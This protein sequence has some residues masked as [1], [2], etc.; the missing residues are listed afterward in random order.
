MN[1][2]QSVAARASCTGCSADRSFNA[3]TLHLYYYGFKTF[4]SR[5]PKFHSLAANRSFKAPDGMIC[6]MGGLTVL[7]SGNGT[8]LQAIIDACESG[9]ISARVEL[10]ISDHRNSG[11]ITR[12]IRHGIKHEVLEYA[13]KKQDYFREL[14]SLVRSSSPNLVILA[15]FMKIIP[16]W[17]VLDITAPIINL[18]PSLLPCFGGKS[19]YGIHVH[20]SVISSGAKY[21]GCTVHIVTPEV[22]SGPI[23]LQKV[24]EVRDDDTPATL[25]DRLKPLEHQAMVEAINIILSGK[26]VVKGNRVLTMANQK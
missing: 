14:I 22:D 7:A 23:I 15:G 17:A 12:A 8:T 11:A 1:R 20:E 6:H 4:D 26:Y 10:V 19:M 3:G 13:I 25:Q 24:L 16:G 5:Y 18:H 2:N 21:S 9:K